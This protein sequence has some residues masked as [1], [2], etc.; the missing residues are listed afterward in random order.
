LSNKV[1]NIIKILS[2]HNSFDVHNCNI[3]T[4]PE[5]YVFLAGT[6]LIARIHK[7]SLS[8]Y[9]TKD[10]LIRTESF[11]KMTSRDRYTLLLKILHFCDNN[12]RDDDPLMKIRYILDK[13]KTAFKTA[14]YL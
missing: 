5:M 13:L 3:T 8:E 4:V 9:W 6:M 12:I 11:G 1:I 10:K 7:I 14:S 2:D